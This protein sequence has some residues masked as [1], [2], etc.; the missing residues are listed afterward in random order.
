MI[1]S[2]RDV[3]VIIQF[4]DL[5]WVMIHDSCIPHIIIVIIVLVQPLLFIHSRTIHLQQAQVFIGAIPTIT[6]SY[7]YSWGMSWGLLRHW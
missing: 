1:Y 3:R 4:C 6:H 7:L 5:I 2:F